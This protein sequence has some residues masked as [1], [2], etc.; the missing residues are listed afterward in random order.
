MGALFALVGLTFM[1]LDTFVVPIMYRHDIG[2]TVA[3]GRFLPL[4]GR[5][6]LPFVLY[7]LLV[8]VLNVLAVVLILML[9]FMTCCVGFLIASAPYVGQVVLLPIHVFFR[10]L[11]P[12]FLTQFGS[13]FD[14]FAMARPAT[15][16]PAAPAAPGPTA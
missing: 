1:L 13:D 3:W 16:A 12:E 10:G 6:F 7:V 15:A 11:G 8:W 4:L 9:G 14:V 2:V 5:Q